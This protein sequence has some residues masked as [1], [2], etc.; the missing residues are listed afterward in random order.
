MMGESTAKQL[1]RRPLGATGEKLSVVAL[2]GIV[3]MDETP[4]HAANVVAE[5]VDAGVNY[6]DVA[7]TYGN[8]EERLGPALEP[9]RKQSFLACKTD[10][11]D[12]AG[13][14]RELEESLRNL[15]TDYLDLYQLHSIETPQ[16]VEQ[17]FAPGGAIEVLEEARGQGKVRFLG[18]SAHSQ[19]AALAAMEQF[20]FDTV[21]LPLNWVAWYSGNFGSRVVEAAQQ[22][23]MGILALKSM[24]RSLVPDN[25]QPPYAKCWYIPHD[26]PDE[27]E[28]CVRFTLSLPV[29]ALVPPGEEKLWRMAVRA[30]RA[31][32]PLSES[33]E[34][35]LISLA[36]GLR[37]VMHSPSDKW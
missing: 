18:F 2:G 15:R 12:A 36:D 21:L 9:Y 14:R 8:A 10:K 29:T 35:Q 13:A 33:E 7:P 26:T 23:G 17:V 30:A 25:G 5:A 1:E 11:R 6:F 19:E 3:V 28:Q 22:K 32:R 34:A 31:F 4:E 20:D 27:V 24:A 16:D 37:P